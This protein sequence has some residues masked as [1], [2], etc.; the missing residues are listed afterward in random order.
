MNRMHYVTDFHNELGPRL[1]LDCSH[2][3]LLSYEQGVKPD[4]G[5][6]QI[7]EH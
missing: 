1:R 3:R 7:D 5:E 6:S 2:H 4:A